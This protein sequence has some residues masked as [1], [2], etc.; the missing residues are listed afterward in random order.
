MG[1]A[2]AFSPVAWAD[3]AADASSVLLRNHCIADIAADAVHVMPLTDLA[4]R[5]D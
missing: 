3:P 1:H 5:I 2:G 4:S